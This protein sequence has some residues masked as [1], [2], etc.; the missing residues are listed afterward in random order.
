MPIPKQRH[1]QTKFGIAY[2]P[3]DKLK[4]E[5][6]A[7]M[8]FLIANELKRG[9]LGECSVGEISSSK[10]FV[11]RFV[12]EFPVT[13]SDTL[14]I[15]NLKQWGMI[16]H[17]KKPDLSNLIKFYEDCANGI[18]FH[19]DSM[20]VSCVMEKK[21]SSTNKPRVIMTVQPHKESHGH[22]TKNALKVIGP[23]RVRELMK[24]CHIISTFPLNILEEGA[25]EKK[26]EALEYIAQTLM[27]FAN[28]FSNDLTKIKRTC[29]MNGSNENTHS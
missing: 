26:N 18:I 16:S 17:N 8:V 20:I 4:R 5:V 7:K 22:K 10:S 13:E 14:S 11:L 12:F 28:E 19:D 23:C 27:M 6:R 9:K 2:D 29:S 21:Y 24:A 3:Q 15:K 1:R 25:N